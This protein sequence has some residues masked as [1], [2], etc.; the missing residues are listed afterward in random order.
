MHNRDGYERHFVGRL[1]PLSR[2]EVSSSFAMGLFIGE[3]CEQVNK[4]FID[5]LWGRLSCWRVCKLVGVYRS[6][7][8]YSDIRSWFG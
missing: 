7:N 6:A 1:I 5:F 3:V 8:E 2:E 4:I